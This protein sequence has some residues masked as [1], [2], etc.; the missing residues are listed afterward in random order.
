MYEYNMGVSYLG[1]PQ[2]PPFI[3]VASTFFKRSISFTNRSSRARSFLHPLLN[4]RRSAILIAEDVI[5]A[6]AP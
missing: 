3:T 2:R 1:L 6:R 5:R 4:F